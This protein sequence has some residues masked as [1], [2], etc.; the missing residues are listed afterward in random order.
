[1]T[2]DSRALRIGDGGAELR[3]AHDRVAGQRFLAR[4]GVI[5]DRQ[6]VVAAEDD[7]G[8]FEIDRPGLPGRVDQVVAQARR[9]RAL[10]ITRSSCPLTTGQPIFL[11]GVLAQRC[12]AWNA[13]SGNTRRS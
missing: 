4:F 5:D 9:W 12:A 10:S 3:R 13:T 6:R 2:V 11:T 8:R 1:M 7:A